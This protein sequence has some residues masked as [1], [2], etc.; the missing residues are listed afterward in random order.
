M[1][2]AHVHTASHTHPLQL[3]LPL[4]RR[5]PPTPRSGN[6]LD[7]TWQE[8]KSGYPAVTIRSPTFLFLSYWLCGSCYP[9]QSCCFSGTALY[10]TRDTFWLHPRINSLVSQQTTSASTLA[11][12]VEFHL[13]VITSATA[14]TE[15]V[16]GNPLLQIWNLCLSQGHVIFGWT[17]NNPEAW[18]W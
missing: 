2:P 13:L 7:V 6:A 14:F 5:T 15:K 8:L 18:Y 10:S 3:L 1:P 4:L 16:P 9:S 11:S 12:S 17:C